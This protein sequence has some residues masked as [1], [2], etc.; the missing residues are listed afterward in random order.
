MVV[1][2]TVLRSA[3]QHY[4]SPQRVLQRLNNDLYQDLS[5][6]GM[7]VTLFLAF[8]D[9]TTQELTY[10]NAGHSPVIFYDCARQACVLWAAD[11]PPVG[12][13][14]R[15]LSQ[16][17]CVTLKPGDLL[18]V[19]SDGF[20]EA[21]DTDGE[22][23]GNAALMRSIACHASRSASG[24]QQALFAE[25]ESFSQ[26]VP[27]A[28]DQTIILLKVKERPLGSPCAGQQEKPGS[29]KVEQV[30]LTIPSQT[31]YLAAIGACVTELCRQIEGLDDVK[32]VAYNLQLAVHEGVANVVEHAHADC[33]QA[34]VDVAFTLTPTSLEVEI[35][36]YGPGFDLEANLARAAAAIERGEI[37]DRTRGLYLI[38]Q[39]VDEVSYRRDAEHGNCLR[40]V[41]QFR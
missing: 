8:Y 14:D 32:Q 18:A 4:H 34:H 26:G 2:R 31:K 12:V 28:D 35:K 15:I 5:Q 29:E 27:Q 41:K 17:R 9:P 39:L 37:S 24:L 40:L 36:D 22:R 21:I 3:L 6:A 33:P 11:G 19:M 16:D 38:K 30:R 1:T 23:W 13:L 7:F 25:V 10:A 20:N